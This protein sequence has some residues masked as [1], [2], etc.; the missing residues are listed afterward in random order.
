MSERYP[1]NSLNTE[2]PSSQI[3]GKQWLLLGSTEVGENPV[4]PTFCQTAACPPPPHTHTT[5]HIPGLSPVQT[6]TPVLTCLGQ[7]SATL[8]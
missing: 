6:E 8:V 3:P 2:R 1:D 7:R 4:Q 5:P